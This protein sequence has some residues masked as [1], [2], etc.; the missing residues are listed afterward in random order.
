VQTIQARHAFA[1]AQ[2]FDLCL[3]VTSVVVCC[4]PREQQYQRP[5]MAAAL[6]VELGAIVRSL[7]TTSFC[8]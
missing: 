5:G 3:S 6:I 7:S 8:A 2:L 1:N 4:H